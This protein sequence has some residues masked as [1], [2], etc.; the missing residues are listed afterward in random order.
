LA[1]KKCLLCGSMVSVDH[2]KITPVSVPDSYVI[3]C[4][5]C[6]SSTITGEAKLEIE[7]LKDSERADLASWTREQQVHGRKPPTICSSDYEGADDAQGYRINQILETLTPRTISERLDRVLENL[8]AMAGKPGERSNPTSEDYY[9]CFASSTKQK[10]FYLDALREDGSIK[11]FGL[12]WQELLVTFEGWKRIGELQSVG[13][14]TN[15]AFVA[16]SFKP[17]LEPVWSDGLYKGIKAAG[18]LPVR[19]DKDEHNEKICDRIISEIRRS[20]FLVADVTRHRQGVYFEA[21]YAMG[22]GI[23]VIWSCQKREMNRAH[24][25]TR[26]YNHIRWET[27]EELAVAL[28]HRIRA[29]IGEPLK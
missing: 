9:L 11:G 12:N 16:M 13:A 25:D 15:Q 23:P 24:F 6:G 19:V 20:A 4:G 3:K 14:R 10:A 8:G 7:K 27:P 18:Y 21:G 26:Q 5:M 29:T 17:T 28:E 2:L 22:L 1:K